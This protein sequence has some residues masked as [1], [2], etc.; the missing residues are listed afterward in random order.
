MQ[1]G[2]SV[3][4]Q[5]A[6]CMNLLK[7]DYQIELLFQYFNRC[8][9]SGLLKQIMNSTLQLST[10]THPPIPIFSH[11]TFSTSHFSLTFSPTSRSSSP[12]SH[13]PLAPSP[14]PFTLHRHCS[15][16]HL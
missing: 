15:Y 4:V 6:C 3:K 8:L 1:T 10:P 7:F 13:T 14:V 2:K 16:V 12:T 5:H 9:K 11:L